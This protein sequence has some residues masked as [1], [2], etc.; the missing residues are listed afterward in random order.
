MP[1]TVTV[2]LDENSAP[3]DF[4]RR[5]I[6]SPSTTKEYEITMILTCI[7]GE[8][9]FV[10]AEKQGEFHFDSRGPPLKQI[11]RSINQAMYDSA[12]IHN[13]LI[14]MI[15]F[16]Q[17]LQ[18]AINYLS[19]DKD[20]KQYLM[21]IICNKM[22]VEVFHQVTSFDQQVIICQDP[23]E[24]GKTEVIQ[25][26]THYFLLKNIV[27][28]VSAASNNTVNVNALKLLKHLTSQGEGMQ[29]IYCVMPDVFKSIYSTSTFNVHNDDG[30]TD[31]D[32]NADVCNVTVP[33]IAL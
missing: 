5:V 31:D 23:P 22:Q 8:T 29:G 12:G 15:L 25:L 17:N 9:G 33:S 2:T 24:I 20:V 4:T 13:N 7:G 32:V 21:N 1:V 30:N 16:A 28:L 6:P 19:I 10:L 26:L 3:V 14:K 18:S 11:I 27:F